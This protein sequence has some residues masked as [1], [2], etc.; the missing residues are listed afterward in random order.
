MPNAF[1]ALA[2]SGQAG[3]ILFE[4]QTFMPR[5]GGTDGMPPRARGRSRQEMLE[6]LASCYCQGPCL[7]RL[8]SQHTIR[9][10]IDPAVI[11]EKS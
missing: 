9:V 2:S 6:S 1:V 7:G 10:Q 8:R 3:K 4:T 11:L 5:D